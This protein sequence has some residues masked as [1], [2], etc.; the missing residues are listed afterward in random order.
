MT[1]LERLLNP[2]SIAVVGGGPW[3]EAVIEQSRHFNPEAKIYPVHPSATNLCGLCVYP[4]V[5][6]LPEAPDA[7]FIGINRD[8]TI[9][10]VE[11]LRKLG[12]GGAVCFASGFAEM[13]EEDETADNAQHRL[14]QAAGDMPVLGPNCYGLI[15][16]LDGAALWPDQHGCTRVKRGVAILTQSSNIAIN[17]TMQRRGLPIAYMITCGNQA[18]T[19]QAKLA[20]AMLN[21]PRVT[22][23]GLHIEGFRDIRE[24]ETLARAAQE[25]GIPLVALKVGKS[26]QARAATISHTASL[27]GR[28]AGAQAILTRLGIARVPDLPAFLETLKMLHVLGSPCS[29]KIAAISCSGG[30]ASL[31]ADMAAETSLEFPTLSETQRAG[32]RDAL[33]PKV[34]L[35]NPLDYHTFIWRDENRMTAAWSAMADPDIALTLLI[36][37]YPRSDTCD[38]TDWTCATRAALRCVK[39]SGMPVAIVATLPELMPEDVCAELMEGGVVPFNGLREALCAIDATISQENIRI[40]P[41]LSSNPTGGP[42]LISEHSAKARLRSAG[43]SV[44]D[45]VSC[46]DVSEIPE[47]TRSLN[48]PVAVKVLGLAH[49]S[50]A[51]GVALNCTTPE[52]AQEA[53]S[54]MPKAE[55]FLIEEMIPKGQE[56]LVGILNDPPHGFLLTLGAGGVLTE[57]LSDQAHLL[58]PASRDQVKAALESL[59]VGRLLQGYRGGEAADMEAIL[60][61]IEKLQDYTL[62]NADRLF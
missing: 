44:P 59:K 55:G 1:G 8:A 18:Q 61:T 5:K 40:E 22:A 47:K 62:A 14:V 12:A 4:S 7:T 51:G 2:R 13:K 26:R 10:V 36:I 46:N 37:D 27:A 50:D 16:A 60:G 34:K 42:I 11:R 6:H 28:D 31:V 54:K 45:G 41:V 48:F 20:M 53:A 57:L 25:K 38:P 21:D 32:L 17:L 29:N 9:G 19:S 49:K 56:L 35:A 33:G 58:I 3:C 24:W 52:A 15:N 43:L 23:I 30:E 39:E